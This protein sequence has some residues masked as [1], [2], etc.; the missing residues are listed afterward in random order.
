MLKILEELN[1]SDDEYD[2]EGAEYIEIHFSDDVRK[3]GPDQILSKTFE[4]L[5]DLNSKF[6]TLKDLIK[7]N[8]KDLRLSEYSTW[9]TQ[10]KGLYAKIKIKKG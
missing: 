9:K 4:E 8:K 7:F 5:K 1:D 10:K 2:E 3:S 6:K